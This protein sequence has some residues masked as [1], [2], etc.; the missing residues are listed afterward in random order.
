MGLR[1]RLQPVQVAVATAL[2][3]VLPGLPHAVVAGY[4]DDEGNS[5]EVVR[6]LSRRVPV[7]WLLSGSPAAVRWLVPAAGGGHP[8]HLLPKDSVRAYLAYLTARW[9]FFTHG[10]YGSPAPPRHKV[11]VNLWHGDGP[12]RSKYFAHVRSTFAVAGT[13]MWGRQRPVY[14]G[15]EPAGV[16]VTGHPRLDQLARPPD[17]DAVRRLGLDPE[18]PLVLWMPTYRSTE[19][20]GRR[21]GEVRNWQ[22]GPELSTAE[23]V[24]E[25][26]TDLARVADTVGVT[27]AVKPHPLDRDRY[28]ALGLPVVT[29]EQLARE[30]VTL[31]G[32]LGRSAGLVTDYSSVWTDYL[33]LDRPTGFYCPDLPEYVATRG[34]NVERY[35]ELVP[36]PFLET[37]AEFERFLR[38]CVE[39]GSA[40]RERR[41][42][43]RDLVGVETRPGASERLLDRVGVA[44]RR[45]P[46]P[47]VR[48]RT[49]S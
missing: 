32:L 30:R 22:D 24:K 35:H 6:A 45:D 12:K 29:N 39:E 15:V 28:A 41:H 2:L 33:V 10:L 7:F 4:P 20:R 37:T 13:E 23:R 46:G 14:F 1:A 44:W 48:T 49:G 40:S 36:G 43:S 34:L 18:R 8:V 5:V 21:L 26:T 27:L 3:R 17:D 16:L 19:F 38:D 25:L 9:V 42:R 47:P 11:F 31:Y